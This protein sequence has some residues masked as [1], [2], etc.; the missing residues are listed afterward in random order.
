MIK[1]LKEE[2]KNARG[3]NKNTLYKKKRNLG[4]PTTVGKILQM[5]CQVSHPLAIQLNTNLGTAV[6]RPGRLN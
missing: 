1:N 6:K 5:P 2:I 4:H 3:K